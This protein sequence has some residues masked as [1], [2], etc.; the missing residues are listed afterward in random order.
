V[1]CFLPCVRDRVFDVLSSILEWTGHGLVDVGIATVCAMRDKSGPETLTLEDLDA[2]ADEIEATYLSGVLDAYL[3]CVFTMNSEF[4]NPSKS[5]YPLERRKREAQ[6]IVRAHRAE[7]AAE[8]E[9][10][11]CAFSGQ[12]ATH[13]INRANMPMLTGKDVLNF[14]PAASGGLFVSGP[15]LV[16]LQ[17]LPLGGRRTEGKLLAAHSDDP[18]LTIRLARTYLEDN[19]RLIALAMAGKLPQKDGPDESLARE[20]GAWDAQKKR[21]KYPDAKSAF[22]L[23]ADDLERTLQSASRA[24]SSLSIYWL[25]NSGQGPSLE[26]YTVPSQLLAFLRRTGEQTYQAAWRRVIGRSWDRGAQ[27]QGARR[28]SAAPPII[29]AGRSRNRALVDLFQIYAA[30]FEDSAAARRFIRAHIFRNGTDK[31]P[32]WTLTEL[33]LTEIIGM[34]SDRIANI[35]EFSDRLA[36]Y[37][38]SRNDAQFFKRIVYSNKSWEVRN[39]LVKAQRNEALRGG[40]LLF[41]LD[42]YLNV[43]EA[44]DS[45]RVADWSLVRDLICIRMVE[46]LHRSGWLTADR[47]PAV[48]L[49][50]EPDTVSGGE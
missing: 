36:A 5:K 16:A 48:E 6:N 12:P 40:A 33:F 10:E 22:T 24:L 1:S 29:G 50:Q 46:E 27:E 11:Q 44:D 14:F 42:E 23:I 39:A 8:A 28:K 37:V 35:K 31:E 45:L 47:A 34:N 32:S 13:K 4:T 15:Y 17:A 3:S 2:V 41:S 38:Q 30:G 21:P 25:S 26:I 18:W 9:G 49:E 20:A 43:F 7:P 19:R